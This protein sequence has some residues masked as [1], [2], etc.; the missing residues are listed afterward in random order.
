MSVFS[1]ILPLVV[2]L[3]WQGFVF[4]Q[5]IDTV[6]IKTV[7]VIDEK[8]PEAYKVVELDSVAIHQATSLSELLNNS[9]PIFV[10]TYG[11]GSLASVSFRGTGASHTSVLWNGIVLNSPM[12]GQVDFSLFPTPF[13]DNAELNF[14]ASGLVNGTGALGGSVSLNNTTTFNK[15]FF[16]TLQQ[17]VGSF[18]NYI[19]NFKLGYSNQQWF[20][21]TQLYLNTNDHNFE[22]TNIA[23]KEQPRITQQNA[24]TKQYGLQQAIFRRFKKSQLGVRFWYF[25]SDRQLPTNMLVNNDVNTQNET[26]ADESFRGILEWKGFTSK[27]N[28][29][30]TTAFL[31]DK[32]IYND[33]LSNIY[34]ESNTQVIDNKINGTF[35]LN[36]QFQIKNIVSIRHEQAKADGFNESHQRFNNHWLFGVS[37]QFKRLDATLFNRLIMV[38]DK[39]QPIAPSVGVQYNVLKRNNL[40]I[41]ANTAINYNYPTFNDLYWAAGGNSDLKPEKS[42]MAELGLNYTISHQKTIINTELT[43]FYSH[44]YDWIIWLPTASSIWSPS[45]LREVENK[46]LEYNLKVKTTYQKLNL[47]F[48]GNYAYTLSTNLKAKNDYDNS[49]NKQL[50]YVPYHQINHTFG[51]AIKNFYLTYNYN[52]TGKRFM[53]TDNNWYLPPN[54]ISNV[55]LSKT[56]KLNP[57]TKLNVGFKINNI[58]NQDYQAIAWR[59]MPGRNYLIT[60]TLQFN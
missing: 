28:Y 15:G 16:S 23:F 31:K 19:S 3:L 47:T 20:T 30:I 40:K 9:S 39:I 53:T 27:F 36:N 6:Q 2:L 38:A 44:V 57:Q 21:E 4:A 13:I 22:Y 18:N 14:G 41:K 10:K 24:K 26:Q 45:N 7:E 50:I 52:Y 33:S 56:V 58:F 17:S 59:A 29:K 54:F 51:A 25:N 5:S 11:S 35:Y 34:S 37:K 48:N 8:P 55:S 43:G 12:N 1:K 42:E 49:V 32:L 60:L 46:G